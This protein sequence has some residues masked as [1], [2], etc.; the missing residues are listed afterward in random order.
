MRS[1]L[2]CV[3]T[4]SL[5]FCILA[6]TTGSVALAAT[7]PRERGVDRTRPDREA[8][9]RLAASHAPL[10]ADGDASLQAARLAGLRAPGEL[11]AIAIMADFADTCFYGRQDEFEGP[12]PTSTQ[13]SFYYAAHD[14]LY[15][16]HLLRDVADYYASVSGGRFAL[17]YT[18]HG[19]VAGLD[20]GM[21]FYG[22]HPELGEQSIVLA[23]DAIARLD[24]EVD[25]SLYDTVFLIHAGAGEETD[26]LGNSPEQIYSTY[27]GPDDFAD[28]VEDSVLEQP[29][30]P[31]DDFPEG[32]GIQHVL[33]LPENE[34]QDAF[35]GFS[36]YYGS[37]GVYC[38]EVGLRLGMLSLTDFTPAG[39]PDSQGIGQFGL[40]GYGLFSAGGFVPPEPCAFNKQLMG[41]LDPYPADPDAAATWTLNP[42]ADPSDPLAAA[43]IDLTGAEYFLLEYRLQDPDGN[44]I[45]SFA[46][47]L[48]GNNVPDFYDADSA[49]GDGTPTGFFD[50]ATDEREWFT[51]AEWDFF[52]SDNAAR[53]QDPEEPKGRGSGV[54]IWHIDET[55]MQAAF[56]AERNLFNAD[57]ARKSVDVEEADG[58][59]DLD[60][61]EPSAYWLGADFDSFRG[62]DTDSFGPDTRPDT[63][64][65]GGLFTGIVI[66][67]ISDVVVDSTHVFDAGNEGEYTGI[68][69]AEQMTFRL[70]RRSADAAAPQR[71]ASLELPEVDLAGSH[72]MMTVL[73]DA[74][75]EPVIVV[76]ADGGRIYALREDL[77]EWVD[78]DGD[79]ATVAPLARARTAAMEP[80]PL[81]VP[82]AAGQLDRGGPLE[83]VATA[84]DGVYAFDSDGVA[85][86]SVGGHWGRIAEL[87]GCALPP[88]LLAPPGTPAEGADLHGTNVVIAVVERG[89]PNDR[90]R[91]LDD[92]GA[93][94]I[95]PITLPGRA[96]AAPIRADDLLLIPVAPTHD[97]EG[98]LLQIV[99]WDEVEIEIPGALALPAVPGPHPVAVS[100][101]P[102][103]GVVAAVVDS[104]GRGQYVA[105]PLAGGSDDVGRWDA[106]L[107]VAAPIGGRGAV[108]AADGSFGRV[109]VNGHWLL[110]WP[111][112]PQPTTTASAAQ[113]LHL[114]ATL[115]G[116][117][118]KTEPREPD[119]N[120]D[121]ILF[122]TGD[123]RLV[124]TDEDGDVWPGWPLPGPAGPAGTPA[125]L[126]RDDGRY[127]LAA[128]GAH[129]R[130]AGIDPQT[131]DPLEAV[132]GTL[133][134]W[135]VELPGGGEPA[136]MTSAAM[137]GGGPWRAGWAL[138]T[139]SVRTDPVHEPSL[140]ASFVCYPQPLVGDVLRVRGDA[141]TSSSDGGTV[142][143]QIL[144]LQGE[145]VR[146]VEE[147][148]LAGRAAFDVPV[149][150]ADVASGLYLCRLAVRSGA[151]AATT[152]VKT[153]AIAR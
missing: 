141:G 53:P 54:Y 77:T 109:D 139:G 105:I 57:P 94:V 18:V 99:V 65:N 72:L 25:F 121:A 73:D 50:P 66:E 23:R 122:T 100:R 3:W 40:M 97:A 7:A 22:N 126:R 137:A 71:L 69:Y 123:G 116:A 61:R 62:E 96:T 76:G 35:E 5:V 11:A 14:S 83:I 27:L 38:F 103:G 15:Y 82:V 125:L 128:A 12:L 29:Y 147:P 42:V 143:I 10:L 132:H 102:G 124:L 2:P 60:S 146:D 101:V 118:A 28:A 24:G 113:P 55:V 21:A 145:I 111:R 80:V 13:S 47:D 89:D 130:L 78:Q 90:L 64:T 119:A 9:E 114:T 129:R 4:R 140:E 70:T 67:E 92:A 95:G 149:D 117:G 30:I 32:Q 33:I 68:L 52:L 74:A 58:I 75:G 108:I 138:A 17:D 20:E 31:T 91:V 136:A 151:G 44:G 45:F 56:A 59:Q 148:L 19:T 46:G 86:A 63:R 51:D 134:T 85:L 41:W 36:G 79:P 1:W 131:G 153:I 39:A 37:L 34:F 127:V 106:G 112:R 150:L 48:N 133:Q 120:D 43:R 26:V 81:N 8:L 107:N 104:V 144:D 135:V 88:V 49:F 152:A 98:G 142:R 87:D 84:D 16:D 110:G 93:D 115:P 6:A